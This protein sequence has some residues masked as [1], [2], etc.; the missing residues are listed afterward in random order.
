MPQMEFKIFKQTFED[1]K[2]HHES[3]IPK[4]RTEI[5]ENHKN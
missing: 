4:P 2:T 3:K 1:M 5:N